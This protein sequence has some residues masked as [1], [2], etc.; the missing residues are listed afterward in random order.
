MTSEFVPDLVGSRLPLNE[1]RCV[2]PEGSHCGLLV[3]L[4]AD[5]TRRPGMDPQTL[6]GVRQPFVK[7]Q[8]PEPGIVAG[9]GGQ[10]RPL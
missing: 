9:V 3:G 8:R 1:A 4:Q 10:F 2:D 6:D 7:R 5:T